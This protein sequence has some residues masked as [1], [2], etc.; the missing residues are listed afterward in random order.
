MAFNI[1]KDIIAGILGPVSDI[2]D[3]LHVS[4]EEKAELKNKIHQ[5]AIQMTTSALEYEQEIFR[6]KAAIVMA[7]ANGQSWLQRNWRPLTMISFVALFIWNWTGG[8]WF[9]HMVDFPDWVGTA[10][11]VGLGGYVAG[12]SAEKIAS[13]I[14]LNKDL[15]SVP[16]EQKNLEEMR[17]SKILKFMK[18]AKKLGWDEE[19]T[20]EMAGELFD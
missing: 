18:K 2:I 17:A 15:L 8:V 1:T 6:S 14:T 20:R 7:E 9:G 3:E 4:V 11:T 16:G 5:Q 12:R 10:F 19:T 13:T